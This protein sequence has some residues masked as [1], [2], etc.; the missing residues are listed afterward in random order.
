M[1][2]VWRANGIT[3]DQARVIRKADGD[4][5]DDREWAEAGK[6]LA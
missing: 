5:L 6:E 3:R 2:R 1:Y 4:G